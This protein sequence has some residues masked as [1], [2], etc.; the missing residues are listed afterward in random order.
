MKNEY[1]YKLQEMVNNLN[2]GKV[3]NEQIEVLKHTISNTNY[4]SAA[5]NFYNGNAK[6]LIELAEENINTVADLNNYAEWISS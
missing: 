1:G 6:W 3:V 4:A 5:I 2:A